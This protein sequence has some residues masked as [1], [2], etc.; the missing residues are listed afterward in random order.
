MHDLLAHE[1]LVELGDRLG[2]VLE[3]QPLLHGQEQVGVLDGGGGHVGLLV[4]AE[5]Q[6][7]RK[8]WFHSS[9]LLMTQYLLPDCSQRTEI[10]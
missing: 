9:P 4:H 6:R 7:W 10:L 8:R 3:L 5:V 2:G 1:S